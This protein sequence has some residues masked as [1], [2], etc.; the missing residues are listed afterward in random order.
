M[1]IKPQGIRMRA[2]MSDGDNTIRGFQELDCYGCDEHTSNFF[3][4]CNNLAFSQNCLNITAILYSY[5]LIPS[6]YW[7]YLVGV[8]FIVKK[9]Y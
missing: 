6:Q 2:C 4:I 8:I 9:Q 5:L 7:V 1:A 3:F